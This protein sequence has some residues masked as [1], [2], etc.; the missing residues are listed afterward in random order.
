MTGGTRKI[1]TLD[2]IN[3]KR[4]TVDVGIIGLEGRRHEECYK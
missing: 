2:F 1:E 3:E 4:A